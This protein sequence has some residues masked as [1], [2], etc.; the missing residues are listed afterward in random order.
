MTSRGSGQHVVGEAELHREVVRAVALGDVRHRQVGDDAAAALE[1]QHRVVGAHHEQ[2]RRVCE[3]DALGVA[4]GAGR[5]DQRQRVVGLDGRQA[6]SKSK[7]SSPS[8]SSRPLGVDHLLGV[9]AVA[10]LRL[11]DGELR[12]ESR[13]RNSTCSGEGVL[14]IE[15]GRAPRCIAAASTRWNSG[16]LVSISASRSPRRSPRAWRPAAIRRTRRRTRP[17]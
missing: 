4:G 5:V 6:A 11:D 3:H 2:H 10:E 1:V 14:Y 17:R 16:R 13:R 12:A 9:D 15:N 8:S 7:S